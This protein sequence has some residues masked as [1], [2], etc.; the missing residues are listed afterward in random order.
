MQQNRELKDIPIHIWAMDSSQLPKQFVGERIVF[1]QQLM[2]EELDF[3][4]QINE[5]QSILYAI[6][7]FLPWNQNGS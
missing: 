3:H 1:C 7:Y 6:P 2:L 4:M 5:L